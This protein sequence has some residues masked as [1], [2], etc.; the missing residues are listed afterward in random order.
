[1]VLPIAM[2]Q[3]LRMAAVQK[4]GLAITFALVLVIVSMD[5]L[6]TIY[7]LSMDLSKGQDSN[8]LWGILEPTIAVIVCAL[9]CYR[10]L[11]KFNTTTTQ[12]ETFW[13]FGHSSAWSK[14]FKSSVSVSGPEDRENMVVTDSSKEVSLLNR[15]HV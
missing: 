12:N 11:L 13:S 14:I 6:R 5:I 3:T 8:A 2:I 4:I 10:G 15:S 7:T 9:P 1:M